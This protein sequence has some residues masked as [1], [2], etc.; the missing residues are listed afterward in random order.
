[1]STARAAR[2]RA[3]RRGPER[4]GAVRAGLDALDSRTGGAM[5]ARILDGKATAAAIREDLTRRGAELARR[6]TTPGLGTV[7]AGDDPGTP[8]SV[9][10]EHRDSVQLGISTARREPPATTP[11]AAAEAVRNAL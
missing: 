3:G 5:T 6:G 8:S 10:G 1:M 2:G 4:I 7:L 11:P 9:N